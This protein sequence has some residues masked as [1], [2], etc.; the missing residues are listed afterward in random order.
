MRWSSLDKV[1][2]FEGKIGWSEVIAAA[3]LIVALLT[4]FATQR[5]IRSAMPDIGVDRR[6]PLVG[7]L[8]NEQSG[9]VQLFAIN[10]LIINNR[11]GRRVALTSIRPNRVLAPTYLLQ[12]SRLNKDADLNTKV[13]IVEGIL[14][15][16][17]FADLIKKHKPLPLKSLSLINSPMDAGETKILNICVLMDAYEGKKRRGE[18]V[19]F[20]IDLVFSDGTTYELR[21]AYKYD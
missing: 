16:V 12:K 18:M 17:R 10:T 7:S 6:D 20:S 5:Q 15:D 13:F 1:F 9:Q 21:Q 4:F 14:G 8:Y 2:K 19:L 11:G 3:A